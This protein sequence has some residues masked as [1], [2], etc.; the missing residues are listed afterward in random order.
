MAIREDL[1]CLSGIRRYC[2]MGVFGEFLRIT[3]IDKTMRIR[4]DGIFTKKIRNGGLSDQ[5]GLSQEIGL[6]CRSYRAM[7][8]RHTSWLMI[9]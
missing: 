3:G 2:E 7:A 9:W 1:Q 8:A 5:T 4:T 6:P